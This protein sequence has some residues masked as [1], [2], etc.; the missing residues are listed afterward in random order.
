MA[1]N[2]LRHAHACLRPVATTVAAQT[3]RGYKSRAH[4]EFTA[5]TASPIIQAVQTILAEMDERHLRRAERW[6]NNKENRV[7][8]RA[9]YLARRGKADAP[10]PEQVREDAANNEYRR[11]DETVELALQLNLDPR[12]PGQSLRGSLALPHGNGKA[13]AVA[14]FTDS[15]K[16]AEEA[17]ER[18]AAV[19]GGASLI[20]SIQDGNTSLS[21]FQRTLASPDMMSQLS[22]VARLL[23]PRG[24]MPN[25]K[26][27][28]IVPQD[29]MLDALQKQMSGMSNYRTDKEGIVRLGIGRGSFGTDKLLENIR[30]MMNTIQG[31]KPESF[32][33]G[34]KGQ[35]KVSKGAKYYLKAHLSS[36]QGKG[37][38]MVDL[39]TIDP[40][41]SFFMSDTL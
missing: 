16:L 11:M 13:F 7:E 25:P 15:E 28:T 6:E 3:R 30:E 20:K 38:V 41:S 22:A 14:V 18:G 2:L 24:L 31:V 8:Q 12:K 34:K 19:A 37:S 33:K 21:S 10:T 1:S 17:L 4:P 9:A 35:K 29:E 27:G 32:G 26:L 39:R 23:G 40:T 5:K 36:T